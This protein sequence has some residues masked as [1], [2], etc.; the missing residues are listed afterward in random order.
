M[1]YT[2]LKIGIRLVMQCLEN[3]MKVGYAFWKN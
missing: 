2:L 3:G 1:K